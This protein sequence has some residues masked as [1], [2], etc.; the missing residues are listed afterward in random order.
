MEDEYNLSNIIGKR[1]EAALEGFGDLLWAYVVLSKKD[2]ACIFGVTNYPSEWVKKYQEQGL[3]YIDPVV[4]TARNRLTPFAWDEQIMADAGL[5]FPELFE[6]AR[7]FGV[8][9]GYTFGCTITTITS[10]R[11]LL[12]STLSRERKPSRRSPIVKAIFRYCWPQSMSR[13]W[14]CHHCQQKTPQ[15]WSVTL[16]LPTEKTKSSIGPAWVKP[17]RKRR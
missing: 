13:I 6:Q 5:H 3:Q 17:T 4:L 7:E 15:P 12:P 14:R 9:H 16:A 1:L 10:S 11:F 2:I 8:T